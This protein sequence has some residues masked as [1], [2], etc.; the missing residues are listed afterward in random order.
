MID[1][2]VERLFSKGECDLKIVI[3]TDVDIFSRKNV[4]YVT[5]EAYLLLLREEVYDASYVNVR[6]AI[7]KLEELKKKI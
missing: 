5:I 6:Q 1:A 7:Q 2:A 3:E 4:K